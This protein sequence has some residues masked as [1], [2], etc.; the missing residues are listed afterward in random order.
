MSDPVIIA[1]SGRKNAGK[2]TMAT[3]IDEYCNDKNSDVQLNHRGALMV[4]EFSFADDL[5]GFCVNTLCLTRDQCFGSDADKMVIT[6]YRWELV[7]P[8]L[9]WKFGSREMV[10]NGGSIVD[11]F[12]YDHYSDLLDTLFP[13]YTNNER[14]TEILRLFFYESIHKLSPINLRSGF[15]TGRDIMQI[16]GTELIRET[17]GNVW[18]DAT[19]RRIKKADCDI[20]VIK[21][22]RAKSFMKC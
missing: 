2:N 20:D 22:L 13:T 5:K 15:M 7:S 17:F 21:E 16:F 1:I 8:F 3:F 14:E 6:K 4:R 19:I 9:R 18:A 12:D 11:N 10:D